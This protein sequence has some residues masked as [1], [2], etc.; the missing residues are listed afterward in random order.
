MDYSSIL[1]SQANQ[2]YQ[3]FEP[4]IPGIA[5]FAVRLNASKELLSGIYRN[6]LNPLQIEIISVKNLKQPIQ[7][8]LDHLPNYI[9]Y[10]FLNTL[11]NS[12]EFELSETGRADIH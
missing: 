5:N 6:Y 2:F 12:N 11:Q 9:R 10:K 7:Y 1:C 8:S 3:E 4:N